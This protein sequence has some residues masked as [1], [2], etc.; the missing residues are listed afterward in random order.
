M[1]GWMRPAVL[2]LTGHGP[3]VAL[4]ERSPGSSHSGGPTILRVSQ[5]TQPDARVA[6][7]QAPGAAFWQEA[8]Q[9]RAASLPTGMESHP[10]QTVVSTS[11]QAPRGSQQNHICKGS[12]KRAPNLRLDDS[13][14]PPTWPSLHQQ[15]PQGREDRSVAEK[16]KPGTI[17]APTRHCAST[18]RPATCLAFAYTAGTP[19][20]PS[21]PSPARPPLL[22]ATPWACPRCPALASPSPEISPRLHLGYVVLPTPRVTG[23]CLTSQH[24]VLFSHQLV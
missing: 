17:Q 6:L 18:P 7:P 15:L 21:A 16:G 2:T 1:P 24:H 10:A 3:L 22:Q 11:S 19:V 14:G 20:H 13:Q 5:V 4:Q 9:L 23:P 8:C 12:S